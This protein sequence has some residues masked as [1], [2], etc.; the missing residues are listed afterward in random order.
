MKLLLVSDL[1]A[2]YEKLEWVRIHA[3]AF[4][5]IAVAGDLLD[6]FSSEDPE[7]QKERVSKWRDEII[8]AG[9]SLVWCSGNH[10]FFNGED[11]PII[12]ASPNWM[13]G[14][15]DR[16]VGDGMTKL[17]KT[18]GGH[19]AVT[20][21]PWPVTANDVTTAEGQI[22]YTDFVERLL[23]EGKKLQKVY[24]W[25]VL[26]HEPPLGLR[27]CTDYAASEAHYARQLVEQGKPDWSLHGHVHESVLHPDGDFVD[28][29]GPTA[30]FNAG[31]AEA[32][33]DPH[34]ITLRVEEAQWAA[35]WVSDRDS[36]TVNGA[37]TPR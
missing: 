7:R 35:R 11:S 9:S 37:L 18:G 10:D 17:V 29:L 8:A 22:P 36:K 23:A 33:A 21:V 27:I 3:E 32:E 28:F 4:D 20:T 16:F 24:P 14:E 6:I 34:Y 19:I 5:L 12:A 15:S 31:Q 26:F 25:L 2:H 13:V 1:H 30:C